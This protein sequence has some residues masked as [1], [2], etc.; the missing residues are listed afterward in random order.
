MSKDD[1]KR[2]LEE[3]FSDFKPPSPE[4]KPEP[5]PPPPEPEVPPRP[6]PAQP[7]VPSGPPTLVQPVPGQEEREKEVPLGIIG[8]RVTSVRDRLIG[9]VLVVSALLVAA[10][11]LI[12]SSIGEMEGA[13]AA[14]HEDSVRMAVV[15]EAHNAAVELL[16]TMRN[17]SAYHDPVRF[18]EYT[19]ARMQALDQ[20]LERVADA[21][22]ALPPEDS[23]RSALVQFHDDLSSAR[24]LAEHLLKRAQ[25]GDWETIYDYTQ[26]EYIGFHHARL[27]SAI[28]EVQIAVFDREE[29]H[30]AN[31]NKARQTVRTIPVVWGSV[32]ALTLIGTAVSTIRSIAHPIERLTEAIARLAEGHLEERVPIERADEFGHLAAAFNKMADELQSY[33]TE[34]EERVAERTRALQEA[35]AALQRRAVLLEASAEVGRVITSIFDVDELLR[36]TVNLIRER[37]GFYHAGIFLID[38]EGEWAVLRDATGEA[39]EKMK[40]QG[41]RLRV[42]GA[43]MVGWTALHRRPRIALD[44]GEDAV[45]FDNPLLPY[46]RSEVTLPLMVGGHLLGVLDVQ[47]TE[48]AAF[49]EDDVRALQ[50]MADQI[51]VALENA[52]RLS[53]EALLLE[54]TSPIY[55]ASRRLTTATTLDEVSQVIVETVAESGVEG[56]IIALFEPRGSSEPQWVHFV[57]SWRKDG[58]PLIPSGTRLPA[59]AGHMRTEMM[60]R[61]WSVADVEQPSFL[62]PEEVAFF[63]RVGVAA[64]ANIP[65]RIGDK[66]LGFVAAYRREA[67][68]FSQAALR[69][70]EALVDQASLALERAWLL[71]EARRRAEGEATIRSLSDRIAQAVDMRTVLRSVAEGLSEALHAAGVYVELGP[72]TL[73]GGSPEEDR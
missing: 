25:E 43:S 58:S 22:S 46:T 2:S 47:S 57:A 33:Y 42:G 64:V 11:I 10:T 62:T 8:A 27:T 3:L 51:A 67:G 6:A 53:D 48:E 44:V 72:G 40:A 56:C 29:A 41:H 45:H 39:G 23:L 5:P 24:L 32:I 59:A 20:A 34:L 7:P 69:L 54:A 65:L 26:P 30:L 38:E 13:V 14:L 28:E 12:F 61:L 37:F 16:N 68:P 35:N 4:G 49:D 21:A 19:K 66:P 9:T 71:E 73:T 60:Q 31:I 1:L 63:R 70:Y 15:L 36:R 55:R 18:V 50:S 52:R 17:E